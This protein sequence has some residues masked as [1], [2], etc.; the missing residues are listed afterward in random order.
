MNN[1]HL[2]WTSDDFS[3]QSSHESTNTYIGN[4]F[5]GEKSENKIHF[6][7][8]L[9]LLN[10]SDTLRNARGH[11]PL[12]QQSYLLQ[13]MALAIVHSRQ[14]SLLLPFYAASLVQFT[15]EM[16]IYVLLSHVW[17]NFY[18][19]CD[20]FPPANFSWQNWQNCKLWLCVRIK[21][22]TKG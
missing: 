13:S 5:I 9:P 6:F 11:Q 4:L 19:H 15:P 7:K 10:P 21:L 12:H 20:L 2:F 22:W 8:K 3:N 14:N 18:V 17:I 1:F 16:A